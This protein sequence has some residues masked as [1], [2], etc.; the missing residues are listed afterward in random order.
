MSKYAK[1]ATKKPAE[2]KMVTTNF[3][4]GNSYNLTPLSTLKIMATS[5]IFGEPSYYVDGEKNSYTA[6]KNLSSCLSYSIF[7]G[8]FK[9]AK[10]TAEMMEGVINSA[11]EHDFG[12]TLEFA[13]ELRSKFYMRLNPAIIMVLAA[14]HPTRA[15][16]TEQNPGVFGEILKAVAIRPDDLT[17]MVEFYLH[18]VGDKSKMPTILKRAIASR[19]ESFDQYRLAKY[20]GRGMGLVD[21][22]RIV[23]ASGKQNPFINDL[24]QGKLVM[25]QGSET[26]LQLRSSGMKWETIIKTH[27][28][29]LSHFDIVKQ[30]RNIAEEISDRDTIMAVLDK[31]KSGVLT[32]KL[33]PYRYW[34]V[35]NLL[36]ENS[37]ITNKGMILD[38]MEEAIDISVGNMPKLNGRVMVLSDNSGSAHGAFTFEGSNTTV[39]D[40]GNLS[41]VM[42]AMSADDGYVGTF[43]DTLKVHSVS[44]RNGALTQVKS[45]KT[46]VGESTENGIWM[47]FDNAI[48]NKEHWDTVFVYSDQQ[49]GHGG[50]YGVHPK[51]YQMYA[52]HRDARYIDVLKLVDTY[53]KKVNPKMNFFTVQTAGYDNAL[54][55]EHLYRGAILVGWTGK[56]TEFA[57]ALI[58]EWDA[59]ENKPKQ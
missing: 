3:M 21:V 16:F 5:S 20:Q 57:A 22:V 24:M 34:T 9:S 40:I 47:F 29:S 53:R 2:Y 51:E 58:A 17:S 46:N 43:G 10:N 42:T 23:H 50:L 52:H 39:A 28:G 1:S 35:W 41:A 38:A 14:M 36:K 45:L 54:V 11:L 48:K 32:G 27:L 25:P 37:K 18:R 33:F 7:G 6:I 8:L 49:A 56:E 15:S 55:P 26:W 19:L 59:A 12:G 44:K 30:I 31:M 4:G 13:K